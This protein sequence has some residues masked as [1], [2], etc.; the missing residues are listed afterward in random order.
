MAHAVSFLFVFKLTYDTL[1]H[2]VHVPPSPLQA[3]G[4][5]EGGVRVS[6]GEART[7]QAKVPEV[8]KESFYGDIKKKYISLTAQIPQSPLPPPASSC[9]RHW[10]GKVGWH[11]RARSSRP[12]LQ[13]KFVLKNSIFVAKHDTLSGFHVLSHWHVA[14][15]CL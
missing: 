15:A 6:S 3:F 12:P 13:G 14:L 8:Q 5:G 1:W 4:G 7:V 2:L 10:G 11:N 9:C